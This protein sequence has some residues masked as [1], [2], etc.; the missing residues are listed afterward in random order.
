MSMTQEE[1]ISP[2]ITVCRT[3]PLTGFCYGCGRKNEEK[4]IWKD[5]KTSNNWKRANLSLLRK[6]L[7][8]WQLKAFD[9]SYKYKKEK[10]I[11]LIKLH[12]LQQK[13]H[14]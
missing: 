13:K 14:P 11:S 5:P 7:G 12:L 2:C 10:G 4:A 8:D 6:R 3:G 9:K 1:I